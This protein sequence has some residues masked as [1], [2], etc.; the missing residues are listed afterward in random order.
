VTDD[1][2]MDSGL[3]DEWLADQ[4]ADLAERI[5]RGEIPDIGRLEDA[6][7]GV[8]GALHRLLPTIRLLSEFSDEPAPEAHEAWRSRPPDILGDFRLGR[9]IGR[10]GIGVVYEAT[11]ISLGRR[12]AVKV[13]HPGSLRDPRQLRRFEIEAQ[14]AASLQHPGIVPVFAYGRERGVPYFAM[15]MIEGR[16]LAELV[17]DRR[18]RFRCGLPPREVAQLGRQAAEALDYAHRN[19]VLHRDIKPSNLLVDADG[20]LWVADFG[21]ARVRS[22]SD[23]TASGDVI[24]TMRYLSPEQAEGRRGAVDGRSDVYALGATLFELLTLRQVFEGDDR[25]E[26]L[27]RI[28]A[29]DPVAPRRLDPAIP[30]DLETIL[31]KAMAKGPADRYATAGD[32]AAE[33]A[34][35]LAGQPIRARRPT[36]AGRGARWAA[37]RWKVVAAAGGMTA[38]MLVGLV[39]SEWWSNARLR[40]INLRLEME[41]DR[42]DRNAREA[43]DHART[44]ERHALGAQLRLAAEALDA[45]QPERAQQILRDIPLNPAGEVP[46]TFVWRY[47][48]SRARRDVV[49]LVGPTPRFGGMAL[50]PDGKILA[51]TDGTMGLQ[52]RDLASGAP[53]RAMETVPGRLES[54]IFSS[55]GT[56]IAAPERSAD[57]TSDDGFSI[58]EV[59]SGRRRV[60]LPMQRGYDMLIGTFLP[61]GELLGYGACATGVPPPMVRLWGLAGD[62]THPRLIDQLERFIG[63]YC[64]SAGG[65]LLIHEHPA[66]IVLRDPRTGAMIRRFRLAGSGRKI[67]AYA[68]SPG[69]GYVAAVAEPGRRLEIWDGHTGKLLAS[70]AAPE[71]LDWLDFS[72]DGAF[73]A[74]LDIRGDVHLIDRVT[75]ATRRIR[76]EDVDRA[77]HTRVAF[78]PD[79]GRLATSVF[80][81]GKGGGPGPVSIWETAT[82]RR[83]ATFPGRPEQVERPVFAPDGRSLLIPGRTGVRLWRLESRDD[84]RQP[85]GH[86]DEAWSLAFSP[87]GR[88]FA[89]GSDDSEPDPT[90]KVW[91]AATGRLD[92]AW[93]GGEGTVAALAFSPDGRILATGHLTAKNNVRIWDAASG[94]ALATLDGHTDRVRAAAFARDGKTLATASS[95]STIRV[96]DVTSWGVRGVLEGHDDTVHSLAFSP[97]DKTLASAGNDGDVRIWDLE[98]GPSNPSPRVFHNRANLMAMAFAPD[99]KTLAVADTLG[100]ITFWDLDRSTPIRS[101]HGEGDELR[102]LA[103]T[104]DGAAIASAGIKGVI[105]LWDPQTGQELL[106]LAAHPSQV[107]GLAFSPDGS[108]LGSVAHDGSVRLWRAE[109]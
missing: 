29:E 88:T 55:D 9:E 26:L 4:V 38:V 53:I 65:G 13:L 60:R 50:S 99:G 95:D 5:A 43:Q 61:D 1:A 51:T 63:V 28:I 92:R 2:R 100:S 106:S 39:A 18:E 101:I 14:A 73:L 78:S 6:N 85:S 42:A 74:A 24:G 41:I 7:P 22:D 107:N 77:R 69:V 36:W 102:Q 31:L 17:V 10:G 48:W 84:D 104:P 97:V 19:E 96:W 64:D 44:S 76:P 89:T 23:L 46:R 40:A 58:W 33:L 62:P 75:G 56:L 108:I 94:R 52:L 15:R 16:N 45:A 70:H 109:P 12:V 87:D 49:V 93:H 83:L 27:R 21:L 86:K 81:T 103:F 20:R 66:S 37:R 8:S 11:Q 32:L 80:G 90:I 35:F 34:R 82:G 71:F 30:L 72:R 3:D 91:N 105:R 59:A 79:G 98:G 47:V 54:P 25:A 68:G 67:A 57:P